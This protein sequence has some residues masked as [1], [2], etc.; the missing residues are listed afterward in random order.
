[1]RPEDEKS[2][3]N[4]LWLSQPAEGSAMALDEI[5]ERV[6]KLET[7]VARRNVREYAAALLVIGVVAVVSWRESN[8]VVVIGGLLMALGTLFI[9]YHLHRWGSVRT[10]PADLALKDCLAFHR[11]ELLRQRDLLH[12][13]WWWYL[14]PMIPGPALITIGRA[15]E[16]PDRRFALMVYALVVV[17]GFAVAGGLNQRGARKIQ[18]LIDELDKERS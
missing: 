18:Q 1:M 16:R 15:V 2:D 13:V 9:V 3:L 17:V 5:R 10:V 12:N 14:L 4:Q 11:A 6:G 8:V 7:R